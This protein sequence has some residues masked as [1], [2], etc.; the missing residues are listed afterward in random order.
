[1]KC[2]KGIRVILNLN[3][4]LAPKRVPMSLKIYVILT[5]HEIRRIIKFHG[6]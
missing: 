1:M 4:S 6:T 3:L 5:H 2:S